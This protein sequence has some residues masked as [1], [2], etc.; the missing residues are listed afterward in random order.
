MN[1]SEIQQ[2]GRR[3]ADNISQV[4]IGKDEQVFTCIA[5]LLAQGHV[6][7]E[8]MPGSGKT[9]LAKS[10]AKS[11]DGGFRRVQFTPDLLPA[12]L[13]GIN[14]FNAKE[15]SFEFLAG[16]VFTNVLLADEINRAT[17]KTQAGLLECM[18]ERQVTVDGT[19]YPLAETFFV[20]AT[21]NPIDTQGVFPLP[22]AQLDR[23]LVRL[24]LGYP[25]FDSAVSILRTHDRQD[26]S[27]GLAPAASLK[28]LA[29]AQAAV[30]SIGIHE[31]LLQYIVRLTEATRSLSGVL[32]GVSQRGSLA[33][34]RFAR[35]C[36]ALDGRSYVIPDDIRLG[37]VPVFAHRLVLAGSERLKP[38][39][40]QKKIE[41]L[42]K[43]IPVPTEYRI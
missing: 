25:D 35:A 11:L 38:H 36:A 8:D 17:P 26:L 27:E 13:T 5:A 30:R 40:A 24:S 43:S 9:M 28:E 19:T 7:L 32:L 23:F 29:L 33:L 18:E 21:Q 20:I 4:I 10:I 31:D 1:V 22:E 15:S 37:A 6:L 3:L 16:P 42:L 2:L 34:L 12:D 41:E 39:A 14:Y